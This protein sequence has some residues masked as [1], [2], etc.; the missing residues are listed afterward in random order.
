MA[1]SNVAKGASDAL[2]SVTNRG[3]RVPRKTKPAVKGGQTHLSVM[4]ESDV[5][6]VID[7][8]AKRMTEADPM[9]RQTTRTDVVRHWLRT[10]ALQVSTKK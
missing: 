7:A 10:M 1:T 9:K 8:E 6:D 4:I 2:P 3:S 5:V